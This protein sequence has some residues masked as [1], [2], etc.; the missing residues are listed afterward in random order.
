MRTLNTKIGALTLAR[1]VWGA[2]KS[3]TSA[4]REATIDGNDDLSVT[5]GPA[6]FR[7]RTDIEMQFVNSR[8]EIDV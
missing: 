5:R 6:G 4:E 3:R 2:R 8:G 1:F 7:E